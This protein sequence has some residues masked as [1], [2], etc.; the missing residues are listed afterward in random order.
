MDITERKKAEEAQEQ[1]RQEQ[2]RFKDD[3]LSH[4][5]HELRSPL[6]A[7]K[8]FTTILLGGLAGELNHEQRE[9]QKIVLR[10]VEQLQSMIDDLLE[11]TSLESGKLT[12]DAERVSVPDAVIDA[13]NTL[14]GSA[15][16]KGVQVV[17]DLPADLP[18]VQADRTRI[19][20]ILII[21]LDNAIKFSA[22]GG[23]VEIHARLFETNPGFLLIEVSDTGC[24]ISAEMTGRIF[25][26]LY[27]VV[28]PAETSRRGLGLGLYICKELV[29]QHGGEIWVHSQPHQGSTFSFTLP[30]WSHRNPHDSEV[31]QHE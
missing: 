3:F 5:S 29:L 27:Q 21:L 9:Y 11:V 10:N 24:G 28:R 13:I 4:V 20:Q 14:Q 31:G 18:A 2:L 15:R 25:E 30:V 12:V 17:S 22:D 23:V 6:T 26:R 7:I 8:Q 1:S 16:A 19:R